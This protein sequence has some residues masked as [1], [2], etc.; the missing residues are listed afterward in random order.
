M[1]VEIVRPTPV[2]LLSGI[3]SPF[4]GPSEGPDRVERGRKV[5]KAELA[6]PPGAFAEAPHARGERLLP[7]N[8]DAQDTR[9]ERLRCAWAGWPKVSLRRRSGLP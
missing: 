4:K 5:L 7:L 2:S 8:R 3:P 6:F 9:R 1:G